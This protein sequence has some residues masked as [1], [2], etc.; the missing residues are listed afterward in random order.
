[1][2]IMPSLTALAGRAGD[3]DRAF[4][5]AAKLRGELLCWDCCT[6]TAPNC[7]QDEGK[8]AHCSLLCQW[9]HHTRQG[10]TV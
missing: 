7:L 9:E 1:M 10:E 2:I 8:Q 5:S 6:V 3:W 4:I